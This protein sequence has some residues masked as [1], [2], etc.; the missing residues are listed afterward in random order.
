MT[1]S[2][3]EVFGGLSDLEKEKKLKAEEKKKIN[4]Q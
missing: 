2:K 3:E 1:M 4:D